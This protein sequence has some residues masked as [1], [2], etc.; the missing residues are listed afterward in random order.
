MKI[1]DHRHPPRG[2]DARHNESLA[3]PLASEPLREVETVLSVLKDLA[4][5]NLAILGALS[6]QNGL[7]RR[8]ANQIDP[9]GDF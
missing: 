5:T 3:A 7:L 6:E 8:M 2:G 4:E 9:P 1:P